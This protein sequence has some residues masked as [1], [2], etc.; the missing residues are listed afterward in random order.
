MT[1]TTWRPLWEADPDGFKA[2]RR[3][4]MAGYVYEGREKT[5]Q[6]GEAFWGNPDGRA[7]RWIWQS[8]SDVV[9]P[10]GFQDLPDFVIPA[11]NNCYSVGRDLTPEALALSKF[12][13]NAEE[14]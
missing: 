12:V 11:E 9:N 6:V 2:L 3:V 13:D 4:I 8:G 10:L 14:E 1:N 5:A 7:T